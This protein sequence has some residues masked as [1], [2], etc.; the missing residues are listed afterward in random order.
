MKRFSIVSLTCSII[1]MLTVLT[2]G[3]KEKKGADFLRINDNIQNKELRAELEGLRDEFK[4]ER[5]R[6]HDYYKEKMEAIKESRGNEI[7]TIKKD[8][9]ERREVLMK[10]YF[11]KMRKKPQIG[12]TEQIDKRPGEKKDLKDNKRI[13]KPE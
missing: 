7:R 12:T 4:F 13:R 2:A 6:I 1:I 8:F 9:S 5:N 10:K 3:V 11:G